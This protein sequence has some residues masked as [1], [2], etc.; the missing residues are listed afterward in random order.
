MP[1][2]EVTVFGC[3]GTKDIQMVSR[4]EMLRDLNKI[5]G[6]YIEMITPNHKI[7]YLLA[8]E[9]YIVNELG[10]GLSANPA[11][12]GLVGPVVLMKAKDFE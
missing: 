10:W 1:L 5:V 6:G 11:V 9:I 8:D 2:A 7:G 4:S 12:P 3:D